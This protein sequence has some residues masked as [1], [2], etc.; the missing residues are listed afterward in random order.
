MVTNEMEQIISCSLTVI[1]NYTCL[2]V[3]FLVASNICHISL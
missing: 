2:Y 3:M 1:D